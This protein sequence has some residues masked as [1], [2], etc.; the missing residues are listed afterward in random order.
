M[1]E[2]ENGEP[3]EVCPGVGRLRH[4]VPS[5]GSVASDGAGKAG[6]CEPAVPRVSRRPEDQVGV[7]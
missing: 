5:K 6:S 2:R 4:A 3:D 1:P 7:P